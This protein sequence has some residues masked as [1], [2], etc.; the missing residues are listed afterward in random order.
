MSEVRFVGFVESSNG[1]HITVPIDSIERIKNDTISCLHRDFDGVRVVH[2]TV[3]MSM[4]MH[5]Q[6]VIGWYIPDE[7]YKKNQLERERD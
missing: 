7:V 1:D 3:T 4:L 6:K 2:Y 5:V